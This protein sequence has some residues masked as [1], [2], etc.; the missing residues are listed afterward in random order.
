MSV[1]R[2]WV[3]MRLEVIGDFVNSKRVLLVVSLIIAALM[4]RSCLN[5]RS[6]TVNAMGEVPGIVWKT[7]DLAL[8]PAVGSIY[9]TE[10][11]E[12]PRRVRAAGRVEIARFHQWA[13]NRELLVRDRWGIPGLRSGLF[14]RHTEVRGTMT[15]YRYEM[16]VF[17]DG[18]FQI[19]LYQKHG[20]RE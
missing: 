3:L 18:S 15:A 17:T 11:P 4:V 8:F 13:L 1:S 14:G 20:M 5:Q 7:D 6:G 10:Y 9:W 16:Q 19:D 2:R 12:T